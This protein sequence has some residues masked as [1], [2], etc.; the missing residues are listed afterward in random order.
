MPIK[1]RLNDTCLRRCKEP[2][3][4]YTNVWRISNQTAKR[5]ALFSADMVLRTFIDSVQYLKRRNKTT[6]IC[7]V[8]VLRVSVNRRV[9]LFLLP[10]KSD[11]SPSRYKGK[12]RF[13][14]RYLK[15]NLGSRFCAKMSRSI[16]PNSLSANQQ[17]Y[18][19]RLYIKI[20]NI[21][22]FLKH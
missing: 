19:S 18:P 10:D 3:S 14:S 9:K 2:V 22:N 17:R 16:V 8:N 15:R 6:I 11:V 1:T 20:L 12:K 4:S 21:S 5:T 13:I 7:I